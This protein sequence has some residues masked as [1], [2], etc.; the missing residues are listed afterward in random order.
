MSPL[1]ILQTTINIEQKPWD[2]AWPCPAT[3]AQGRLSTLHSDH[4]ANQRGQ[5]D[6]GRSTVW[7]CFIFLN[8][9]TSGR[10]KWSPLGNKR[11]YVVE[12]NLIFVWIDFFCPPTL[13]SRIEPPLNSKCLGSKNILLWRVWLQFALRITTRLCL[14]LLLAFVRLVLFGVEQPLST[15]MREFP[16]FKWLAAIVKHFIPWLSTSLFFSQ[17]LRNVF[18]KEVSFKWWFQNG[19]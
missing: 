10:T 3:C 12:A 1:T 19:W 5:S 17:S 7:K 9:Y 14:L 18:T 15:L 4:P 13:C 2:F 11:G 6:H 16:Y 8:M